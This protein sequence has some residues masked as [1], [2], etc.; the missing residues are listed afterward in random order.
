LSSSSFQGA[1]VDAV[2]EIV[3]GRGEMDIYTYVLRKR[4]SQ[5]NLRMLL[6]H[7]SGWNNGWF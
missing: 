7:Q 5:C 1:L 3:M 4:D 2:G 6:L